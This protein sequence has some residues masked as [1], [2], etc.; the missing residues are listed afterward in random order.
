[1]ARSDEFHATLG[2]FRSS[3][4]AGGVEKAWDLPKTFPRTFSI[5]RSNNEYKYFHKVSH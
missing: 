5:E 2:A 3:M 1:M 4:K